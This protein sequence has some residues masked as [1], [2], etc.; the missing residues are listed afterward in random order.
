M[1]IK[2]EDTID[3]LGNEI[4]IWYSESLE[5]SPTVGSFFSVWTEL[6]VKGWIT[7]AQAF[8]FKP[9]L[10]VVWAQSKQGVIQGGIAYDYL[11]DKKLGWIWLSFTVPEF[12]GRE[13]NQICHRFFES[14]CKKRGATSI[15]SFVNVDNQSRLRSAQKVGMM[16][17]FYRMHKDI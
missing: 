17:R 15:G 6:I 10:K 8:S 14:D 9:T 5:H 1:H 3:K 7:S 4:E 12:R 2:I 16:P 13:I 11:E